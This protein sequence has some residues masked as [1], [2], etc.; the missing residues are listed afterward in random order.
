MKTYIGLSLCA[1]AFLGIWTRSA[2]A[3]WL[4]PERSVSCA[5]DIGD[6]QGDLFHANKDTMQVQCRC[7]DGDIFWGTLE[8]EIS[9][10]D[11][12]S[13]D[14]LDDACARTLDRC[15]T[16]VSDIVVDVTQSDD[17]IEIMC[18]S[19][20]GVCDWSIDKDDTNQRVDCECDGV[21]SW[22]VGADLLGTDSL[23]EISFW[24]VSLAKSCDVEMAADDVETEDT[25]PAVPADIGDD[26]NNDNDEHY[27]ADDD[28]D[29][30]D[31]GDDANDADDVNDDET[32]NSDAD[33]G[34]DAADDTDMFVT[35]QSQ[36]S[37]GQLTTVH[38]PNVWQLLAVIFFN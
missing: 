37:M 17:A 1:F 34:S 24:C 38:V 36:C 32:P 18:E 22:G 35:Q 10:A 19:Q 28:D 23:R 5:S 12:L 27:D 30:A 16:V 3:I 25:D 15:S 9:D 6:C 13:D 31:D 11:E 7:Y 2:T 4:A 8:D 33:D 26:D 29:D 20:K 21:D 14:E